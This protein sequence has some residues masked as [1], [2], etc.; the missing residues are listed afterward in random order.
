MPAKPREV[1]ITS[2]K[3]NKGNLVEITV[4]TPYQTYLMVDPLKGIHF[5]DH[6][7]RPPKV[8]EIKVGKID[9]ELAANQSRFIEFMEKLKVGDLA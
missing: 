7:V 3:D 6:R 1:T 2:K 8:T 5:Q 4:A 9:P